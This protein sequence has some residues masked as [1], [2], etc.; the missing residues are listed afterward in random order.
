MISHFMT[1]R[2]DSYT[3]MIYVSQPNTLNSFT[4]IERNI[5][6][7]LDQLTYYSRFNSMRANPDKAQ[8]TAFHLR[9][10]E[11][12]PSLKEVWNKT[13]LENTPT[14]SI[15]VLLMIGR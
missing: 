12:K 13:E 6:D 14:Q 7:E 2:V 1:E 4:E 5:G 8:V 11:A 3:Q 15:Y 9:N 10:I